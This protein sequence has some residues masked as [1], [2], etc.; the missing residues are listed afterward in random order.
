MDRMQRKLA[1]KRKKRERDQEDADWGA[2]VGV[3]PRAPRLRH[4]PVA[5]PGEIVKGWYRCC[6]V[7]YVGFGWH[8]PPP[9]PKCG[10]G[11]QQAVRSELMD[12]FV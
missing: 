8:N 3:A 12:G 7:F 6:E 4:V 9:C 2:P 10:K 11:S 1:A 5:N